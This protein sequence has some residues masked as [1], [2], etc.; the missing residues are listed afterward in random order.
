MDCHQYPQATPYILKYWIFWN[1]DGWPPIPTSYPITWQHFKILTYT[2]PIYLFQIVSLSV[3]LG[4]CLGVGSTYQQF[5]PHSM[6]FLT[7]VERKR[8]IF[9]TKELRGFVEKSW[10]LLL[11]YSA[12]AQDT[13]MPSQDA[14][15]FVLWDLL[16]S[17]TVTETFRLCSI[18]IGG[19]CSIFNMRSTCAQLCSIRSIGTW[20]KL[21]WNLLH[22][23][24]QLIRHRLAGSWDK[25]SILCYRQLCS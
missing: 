13:V 24:P 21:C 17:W 4:G 9:G 7:G 14:D 15:P 20:V 25:A 22:W 23:W 2:Y 11:L 12:E 6:L 5:V 18:N 8:N 19:K 16:E 3:G 10:K 1:I